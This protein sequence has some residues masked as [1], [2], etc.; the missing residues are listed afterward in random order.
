MY[1]I[2]NSRIYIYMYGTSSSVLYNTFSFR[3]FTFIRFK[4]SKL[5]YNKRH[6]NVTFQRMIN[7]NIICTKRF[8]GYFIN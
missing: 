7:R 1:N 4:I 6:F 5:I 8:I 2:K 3:N